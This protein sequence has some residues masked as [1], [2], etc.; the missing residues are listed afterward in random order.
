MVLTTELFIVSR[1]HCQ[2]DSRKLTLQVSI[3]K[4]CTLQQKAHLIW[5]LIFQ[6]FQFWGRPWPPLSLIASLMN[7]CGNVI[8]LDVHPS[9]LMG[10]RHLIKQ[11]MEHPITHITGNIHDNCDKLIYIYIDVV[12]LKSTKNGKISK[13]KILKYLG[14]LQRPHYD[15]TGNHWL[16]RELIPKWP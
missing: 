14:K 8:H 13:R 7:Q 3:Q 6:A 10:N 1:A 4:A 12:I 11:Y 15:L 16:I 9:Y 5:N 2:T